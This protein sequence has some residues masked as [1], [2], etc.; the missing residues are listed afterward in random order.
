MF[1]EPRLRFIAHWAF[2]GFGSTALLL[3]FIPLSKTPVNPSAG[4]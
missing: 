4:F 1:T 3:P 2:P